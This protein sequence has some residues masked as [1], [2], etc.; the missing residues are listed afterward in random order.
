MGNLRLSRLM[1]FSRYLLGLIV[2]I[3]FQNCGFKGFA[4]KDENLSP[5]IGQDPNNESLTTDI[6]KVPKSKLVHFDI[7]AQLVSLNISVIGLSQNQVLGYSNLLNKIIAFNFDGAS[8]QEV[9]IPEPQ[10]KKIIKVSSIPLYLKTGGSNSNMSPLSVV[11]YEDTQK[12]VRYGVLLT[13]DRS[14]TKLEFSAECEPRVQFI[15][16][17][18]LH[19]ANCI[20]SKTQG[21]FFQKLDLNGKPAGNI[22]QASQAFEYLNNYSRVITND[23]LI[24][25]Q[26]TK[27]L[28]LRTG[29]VSDL[30]SS[31]ITLRMPSDL[32]YVYRPQTN[33]VIYAS[34]GQLGLKERSLETGEVKNLLDSQSQYVFT[35][36]D[37]NTF[38]IGDQNTGDRYIISGTAQSAVTPVDKSILGFAWSS[39]QL[40]FFIPDP[41][42]KSVRVNVKLYDLITLAETNIC[43]SSMP[44][45]GHFFVNTYSPNNAKNYF[46]SSIGSDANFYPDMSISF[47]MDQTCTDL[48][49]MVRS[50]LNGSDPK[51]SNSLIRYGVKSQISETLFNDFEL[52]ILTSDS[53]L[54]LNNG[55]LY[56]TLSDTIYATNS[57]GNLKNMLLARLVGIPK[58]DLLVSQ[59]SSVLRFEDQ[60]GVQKYLLKESLE[61]GFITFQVP[62]TKGTPFSKFETNGGDDYLLLMRDSE[63]DTLSA[64]AYSIQFYNVKNEMVKKENI[65]LNS[66]NFSIDR[67]STFWNN[68]ATQ[69]PYIGFVFK[70]QVGLSKVKNIFVLANLQTQKVSVIEPSLDFEFIGNWWDT[71]FIPEFDILLSQMTACSISQNRCVNNPFGLAKAIYSISLKKIVN[72]Y[73]YFDSNNGSKTSFSRYQYNGNLGFDNMVEIDSYSGQFS[74]DGRWM[75]KNDDS[76]KLLNVY[77]LSLG[78]KKELSIS[79]HMVQFVKNGFFVYARESDST[80]STWYVE[81]DT[82]K[83]E[84]INEL[85]GANSFYTIINHSRA[86]STMN[87]AT[88]DLLLFSNFNNVIFF[89]LV[90]KKII[91]SV[92]FE[93]ARIVWND[94]NQVV[95]GQSNGFPRSSNPLDTYKSKMTLFDLKTLSEKDIDI[96]KYEAVFCDSISSLQTHCIGKRNGVQ[97]LMNY[98]PSKLGFD[99]IT[100]LKS[101]FNL[102]KVVS[103]NKNMT[104]FSFS[105]LKDNG[106]KGIYYK[107]DSDQSANLGEGWEGYLFKQ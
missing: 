103:L 31:F 68:S 63:K 70:S 82:L 86:D 30:P 8:Y 29:A 105:A 91:K 27:K 24:N 44:S 35:V 53:F 52:P 101:E 49:L 96:S 92:S 21:F 6:S 15:K 81:L 19:I 20:N 37:D 2:F 4:I 57:S 88:S 95:L 51:Y 66:K 65:L 25:Q 93:G 56:F 12:V 14:W 7:P 32:F 102:G 46:A 71:Y 69:N 17:S 55:I 90:T 77:D 104:L 83:T 18:G 36:I 60:K 16:K 78:T 73:F 72:G 80:F 47:A 38:S 45:S 74:L 40:A 76:T 94:G 100:E 79:S 11:T 50:R 64:D 87:L 34:Y 1:Y 10:L 33:S 28:D 54:T 42:S 39:T 97:Y 84:K 89:D 107:I 59:W 98:N 61:N 85:S 3:S 22:I 9:A 99:E 48:Y 67:I 43:T 26:W 106:Y 62:K 13:K 58:E 75:V 5:N 23:I 41:I